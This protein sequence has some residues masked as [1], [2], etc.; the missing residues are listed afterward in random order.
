MTAMIAIG[1]NRC[2]TRWAG[3]S[4]KN[5]PRTMTS[6]WVSGLPIAKGC[7][8]SGMFCTGEVKPDNM[9][10]GMITTMIPIIACCWLATSDEMNNAM[11][12]TEQRKTARLANS[13]ENRAGNGYA[14]I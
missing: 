13:S 7:S 12:I 8:Q 1:H 6:M 11:P 2:S 5:S 14:E 9:I 10:A 3:I 4:R